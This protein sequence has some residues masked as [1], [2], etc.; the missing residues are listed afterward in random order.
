MLI[1][2]NI[3]DETARGGQSG[4]RRPAEQRLGR[5]GHGWFACSKA[6]ISEGEALEFGYVDVILDMP[7]FPLIAAVPA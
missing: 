2:L 7:S 6:A 5:D 4:L 3:T 1:M